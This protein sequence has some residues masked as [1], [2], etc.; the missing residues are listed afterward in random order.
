VQAFLVTVV[1]GKKRRVVQCRAFKTLQ[2][3]LAAA[4]RN[5]GWV[6]VAV[7]A[8]GPCRS[9]VRFRAAKCRHT[10]S[11]RSI[12]LADIR[13]M[14]QITNI[15]L[16]PEP[17]MAYQILAELNRRQKLRLD[18]CLPSLDVDFEFNRTIHL[19]AVDDYRRYL[20]PYLRAA[21]DKTD[22]TGGMMSTL[23][24]YQLA[25][26]DAQQRLYVAEGLLPPTKQ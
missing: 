16:I 19:N 18:A 4:R 21:V 14:P 3:T 13:V 17:G 6:V 15:R 9:G 12:S 25:H 7:R 5:P 11:Q 26:I 2:A 23:R 22:P 10:N 8:I 1:R 24:R 20:A